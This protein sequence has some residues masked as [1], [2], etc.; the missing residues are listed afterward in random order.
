[1]YIIRSGTWQIIKKISI[2]DHENEASKT[3]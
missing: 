1:M 3:L 2:Q